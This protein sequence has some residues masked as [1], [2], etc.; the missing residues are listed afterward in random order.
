[1]TAIQNQGN[2]NCHVIDGV[3]SIGDILRF[4]FFLFI[5]YLRYN[6]V[7]F[8]RVVC[9]TIFVIFFCK[10]TIFVIMLNSCFKPVFVLLSIVR[11]Y[12]L[13]FLSQFFF[14]IINHYIR[15]KKFQRLLERW[16]IC[17]ILSTS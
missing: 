14:N 12:H 7:S 10:Q 15:K 17:I 6:Y 4:C 11:K 1:M 13:D 9:P 3:S 8:N 2:N 16:S 5:I